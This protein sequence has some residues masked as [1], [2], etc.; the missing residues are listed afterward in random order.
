MAKDSEL[1]TPLHWA[2]LK[3]GYNVV[4]SLLESGS[5]VLLEEK[6]CTNATPSDLALSKSFMNIYELLESKRNPNI[7]QYFL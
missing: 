3:N 5:D 6:D 1:C 7:F 4:V 2:V